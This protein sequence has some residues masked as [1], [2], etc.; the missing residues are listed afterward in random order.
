[1]IFKWEAC[2]TFLFFFHCDLRQRP[3]HVEYTS[4]RPITEVKQHWA[5]LVLGWVTA[6]EPQVLLPFLFSVRIY[7]KCIIEQHMLYEALILLK[8]KGVVNPSYF[9]WSNQV[10]RRHEPEVCLLSWN[11]SWRFTR[12]FRAK[13]KAWSLTTT[14][15]SKQLAKVERS[16]NIMGN[17]AAKCQFPPTSR[18]K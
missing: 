15:D 17:R 2:E 12:I 6:W 11:D 3:Y 16:E 18:T 14:L 8:A 10:T 5:W 9:I 4:S 7:N 1:M 13:F